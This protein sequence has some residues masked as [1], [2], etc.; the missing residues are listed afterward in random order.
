MSGLIIIV[1][2]LVI[3][4]LITCLLFILSLINLLF[5]DPLVYLLVP[6]GIL[7]LNIAL[8]LIFIRAD[9]KIDKRLKIKSNE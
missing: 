1:V 5:G 3:I 4:L 2:I 9:Q 7:L 6:L 8:L